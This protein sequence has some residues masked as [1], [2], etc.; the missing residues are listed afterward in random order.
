M[1]ERQGKNNLRKR[2]QMRLTYMV[3]STIVSLFWS[4]TSPHP[5]PPSTFAMLCYPLDVLLYA[6]G[7]ANKISNQI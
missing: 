1:Q 4:L 7:L 5:A 2:K 6:E 3:N